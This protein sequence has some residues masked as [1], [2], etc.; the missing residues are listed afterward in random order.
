VN[1]YHFT[2][3]H[4]AEMIGV[5]GQ[6][7][8]NPQPYLAGRPVVWAT[9]LYVADRD[10]LGLTSE[11]L[12]CD[13]TEVRYQIT[14]PDAFEPWTSWWPRKVAP[15]AVSQLT[16]PPRRPRHWYVAVCPVWAVQL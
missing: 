11:T 16:Y 8:P 13:R 3:R 12:A 2:C 14:E 9:D 10:A 5:H 6:L 1:L 7:E 4:R 15:D